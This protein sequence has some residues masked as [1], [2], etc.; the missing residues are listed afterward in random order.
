MS[1][2]PL[3]LATA[4]FT[5]GSDALTKAWLKPLGTP[6]MAVGRVLAPVFFLLPLLFLQD[7]PVLDPVFWETVAILLPLE[8]AA[9][10]CYME[11]LRLSPLSLTIPF[12]AFTPAFM[13]LTGAL[14]LGENLSITGISGILLIVFGSYSLHLNALQSGWTAPI[15]AIFR[16]K[17]SLLMLIVAF[18]YSITSVLGKLA[19][20]HSN[21]LFFA[22]F[23]YIIHGI[24]ATL[25]LSILFKA[26][27]W[28]V[29]RKSPKGVLSVGMAQTITVITHMWAISLAP[30]AY[31][32]A[33]KRLSVLF[34]VFLG[35]V[36]FKEEA[37][38]VRLFGAAFMVAGVFLIVLS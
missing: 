18:I 6:K 16:E 17:G 37:I 14:V 36:V 10:V 19:I 20:Q 21:P 24:F 32:I 35:G 4:L 26:Y 13:I 27:P 8:T 33:V 28:E 34:G 25:V 12:L 2:F 3:S 5:A 30:A 23:Y 7:W 31:M 1:W 11:A 15:K 22:S 9:L 29:A 38:W